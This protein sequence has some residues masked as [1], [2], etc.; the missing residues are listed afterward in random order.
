M[1]LK[2]KPKTVVRA[3]VHPQ[4]SNHGHLQ[5]ESQH[6]GVSFRPE[7]SAGAGSSQ[8]TRAPAHSLGLPRLPRPRAAKAS[9]TSFPGVWGSRSYLPH[10]TCAGGHLRSSMGDL[11]QD[12]DV[13]LDFQKI[14][15][16]K[17]KHSQYQLSRP[18][19]PCSSRCTQERTLAHVIPSQMGQTV[20]TLGMGRG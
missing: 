16:G 7:G 6:T 4:M 10:P 8:P 18:G 11:L 2:K 9:T 12:A 15:S 14:L 19:F 3:R 1:I 20:N 13:G 17:A 5:S